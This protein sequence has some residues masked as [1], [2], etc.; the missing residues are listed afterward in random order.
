MCNLT[1]RFSIRRSRQKKRGNAM[2]LTIEI[3]AKEDKFQEIYQ[4]LQALIP[5]IRKEKGCRE[6]RIFRDVEDGDVFFLCADWEAKA[7]LIHYMRSGSASALLGAIDL[8]SETARVKSGQDETWEGI[9]SL[10]RVRKKMSNHG[11]T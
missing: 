9:D 6:C 3:R 8:L 11:L 5:M 4:I 7:N 10:K 1:E 2:M